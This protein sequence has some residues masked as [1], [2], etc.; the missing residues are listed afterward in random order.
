MKLLELEIIE[1]HQKLYNFHLSI[2]S[3]FMYPFL[4][5]IGIKQHPQPSA[6]PHARP[7]HSPLLIPHHPQYRITKMRS[8]FPPH[9]LHHAPRPAVPRDPVLP[10]RN[11]NQKHNLAA[12][13]APATRPEGAGKNDLHKGQHHKTLRKSVPASQ[14]ELR[15]NHLKPGNA[16]DNGPYAKIQ[17]GEPEKSGNFLIEFVR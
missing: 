2:F 17:F 6:H 5:V 11:G 1:Y 13:P 12:A 9:S 7:P 14:R 4:P 16:K 15:C 10:H 3:F 8:L